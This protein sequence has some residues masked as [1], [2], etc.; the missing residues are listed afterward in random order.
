MT[1]TRPLRIA[2]KPV[3]PQSLAFRKYRKLPLV[4]EA[5]QI[6]QAFEVETLEGL[7]QGDAGDFL[8][9]GVEGELYPCKARIFY[10]T[11]DTVSPIPEEAR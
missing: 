11:Y 9:R 6:H 4:I 7:H 10:K 5:V 2:G 8:L 3:D 1:P